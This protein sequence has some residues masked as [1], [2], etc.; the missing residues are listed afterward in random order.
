MIGV[1][2][3]YTG[4][5]QGKNLTERLNAIPEIVSVEAGCRFHIRRVFPLFHPATL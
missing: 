5:V 2:E 3:M 1:L 4:T